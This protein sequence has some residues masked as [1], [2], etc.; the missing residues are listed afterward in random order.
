MKTIPERI[1]EACAT[2]QPGTKERIKALKAIKWV[3]AHESGLCAA[4][5][6]LDCALVLPDKA[7]VFTACDNEVLKLKFW[8]ASLGVTLSIVPV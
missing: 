5:N 4:L 6:G 3:L 2:T 1:Q 8:Q 7:Q